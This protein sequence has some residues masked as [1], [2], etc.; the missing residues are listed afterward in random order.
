[1]FQKVQNWGKKVKIVGVKLHIELFCRQAITN[2]RNAF[3]Y[4][5]FLK[6]S[7]DAMLHI[8]YKLKTWPKKN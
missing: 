7:I 1:M 3:P 6:N 5:R 2:I 4:G 8:L